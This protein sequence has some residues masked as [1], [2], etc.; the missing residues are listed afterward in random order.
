VNLIHSVSCPVC[1]NRQL[2]TVS[3]LGRG[4]HVVRCINCL[5]E[6]VVPVYEAG[7]GNIEIRTSTITSPSYVAA[8]KSGYEASS[9]SAVI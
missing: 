8:M 4:Y 7:H 3:Q 9:S 2:N 1:E 6:F 5:L